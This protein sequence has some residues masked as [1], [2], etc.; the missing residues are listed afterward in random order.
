MKR[1]ERLGFTLIELL[2]VIA[3]I[4]VLIALLLPA[5]QMARE[6]AR[7]T[8]C[9]NNLKQI[10]IAQH[11]YLSTHKVFPPTASWATSGH[12]PS[13]APNPE[14]GWFTAKTFLL[15]FMEQQQVYNALN[16]D[17]TTGWNS[18]WGAPAGLQSLPNTTASSAIIEAFLCPSETITTKWSPEYGPSSYSLSDGLVR[19]VFYDAQ[20]VGTAWTS[21]GT[22][23]MYLTHNNWPEPPLGDRDYKDGMANTVMYGEVIRQDW[24]KRNNDPRMGDLQNVGGVGVLS[25][26]VDN[27]LTANVTTNAWGAQT[28]GGSWIWSWRTMDL[29]NT[30]MPPNSKICLL[31][32]EVL[33]QV[34]APPM[35]YHPGGVNMLF[36]DGTV[37]SVS[38]NVDRRI[39]WSWGTRNMQERVDTQDRSL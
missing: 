29:I 1:A 5:V 30:T 8:Q 2:V 6:A 34:M 33:K 21:P 9:R 4:A 36:G 23:S 13:Q 20:N 39:W 27:C 26:V 15:P 11:N 25:T 37:K 24:E 22:G 12:S 35:S 7:R 38:D 3:I 31:G 18:G 19:G 28:A 32:T 16:F 17:R 10:G 14:Q